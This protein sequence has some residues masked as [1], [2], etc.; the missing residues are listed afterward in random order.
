M[1]CNILSNEIPAVKLK[2]VGDGFWVT[3]NPQSP[4]ETIYKDIAELFER[5]KHLTIN[6][7]VVLDIGEVEGYDDL[8]SNIRLLLKSR[9]NVGSVTQA[10]RKNSINA[11]FDRHK[12]LVNNRHGNIMSKGWINDRSDALIL[13]GRVRSGQKIET[14]G[15]LIIAGNV[16]PGAQLIAAGNIIVLGSLQGDVYAGYPD[17]EDAFVIALDFKTPNIQIGGVIS[18]ES[19]NTNLTSKTVFATVQDGKIALQDYLKLQPFGK[20]PWPTIM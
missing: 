10:T 17:D 20:L 9:F 7:K 19:N 8:I 12:S 13:A 2:G 4:Q 18:L 6:A 5:L 11:E 16:N 14:K 3:I 1:E 15:H